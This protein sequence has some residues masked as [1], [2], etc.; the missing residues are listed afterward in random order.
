ML[1][2]PGTCH[3]SA[4]FVF[5]PDPAADLVL[6]LTQHF[7]SIFRSDDN[8]FHQDPEDSLD[9]ILNIYLYEEDEP[10]PKRIWTLTISRPP[11]SMDLPKPKMR[12][13]RGR[14][15]VLDISGIASVDSDGGG[16]RGTSE[17]GG[18]Q[19]MA[20]KLG[21]DSEL[22]LRHWIMALRSSTNALLGRDL[23]ASEN[24][25]E[26]QWLTLNTL[27]NEPRIATLIRSINTLDALVTYKTYLDVIDMCSEAEGQ[28]VVAIP[29]VCVHDGHCRS[30]AHAAV[31]SS[32]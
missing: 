18:T 16:C 4:Y 15:H 27:E 20:G 32:R 10:P 13:D 24:A 22:G 2:F 23:S 21:R 25:A 3:R 5:F 1:L 9:E 29:L 7:E 12:S 30:H 14:R 8:G 11:D 31:W 26:N 6:D 28:D 19:R 17:N